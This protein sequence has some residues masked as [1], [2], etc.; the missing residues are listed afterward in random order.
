MARKIC[1]IQKVL[2][3]HRE[4]KTSIS[5]SGKLSSFYFEQIESGAI[6]LEYCK[7][8]NFILSEEDLEE[9]S[10]RGMD[11]AFESWKDEFKI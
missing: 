4:V 1:I 5:R 8:R 3:I 9:I 2:Y 7:K 10:N 6:L 11:D